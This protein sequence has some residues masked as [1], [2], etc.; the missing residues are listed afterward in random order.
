MF[1]TLD[2]S[3]LLE[4]AC[5]KG[6]HTF[7]VP[8]T[9]KRIFAIDTSVD[10]IRAASERA[11]GNPKITFQLSTDG[12][13][14]P[15]PDNCFTSAFSYDA[16]VHFEPITVA[17]YLKE[18][19]RVLKQ[20]GKVLFHHSVYAGNPTGRFTD[21]PNWRNYMTG[22]LFSHFASRAGLEVTETHAFPWS[23]SLDTD[24]VTLMRKL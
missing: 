11:A 14:I 22:E 3:E 19:A 7:L 15:Q 20:G 8:Q 9:Y 5:G 12:F 16:M 23:G 17:S 24:A 18:T 13:T 6:R 2:I 1:Q 21:S 10:A 4:I